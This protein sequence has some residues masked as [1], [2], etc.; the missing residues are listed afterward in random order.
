MRTRIVG[1]PVLAVVLAISLFGVP[2]AAGVLKYAQSDERIR[3]LRV[4]NAAA[5]AVTADMLRGNM[6]TDLRHP[7]DETQ[8]AVYADRGHRLGGTGPEGGDLPV[9]RA[10]H[11]EINTGDLN[12]DLVVAVPVTHDSTVIGAVRTASPHA[13]IYRQVA[14]VWLAMLVLAS[15]TIGTVWLLARRQARR[16]A[17]PA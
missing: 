14:L 2:L 3:L 5:A 7:G 13:A 9:Q 11:G 16:L 1:L 6:P 17:R 8:V 12:G 15:L 4:A 10:L